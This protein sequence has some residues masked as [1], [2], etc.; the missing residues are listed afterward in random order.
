MPSIGWVSHEVGIEICEICK[1]EKHET[2][3]SGLSVNL[4]SP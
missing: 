1:N 2:D 3:D 4:P